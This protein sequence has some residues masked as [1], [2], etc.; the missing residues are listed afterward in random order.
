MKNSVLRVVAYQYSCKVL[1]LE[2]GIIFNLIV[3]SREE[4]DAMYTEKKRT[5]VVPRRYRSQTSVSGAT[6]KSARDAIL[7]R[8]GVGLSVV[9]LAAFCPGPATAER[10]AQ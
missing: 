10:L 9:W 8:F 4:N 2:I 5:E 3:F 1:P 7:N 6:T